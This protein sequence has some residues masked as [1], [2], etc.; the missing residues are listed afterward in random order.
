LR[1]FSYLSGLNEMNMITKT[2]AGITIGIT[3]LTAI[4]MPAL[5]P[6][7]RSASPIP[8]TPSVSAPAAQ[9][10]QPAHAAVRTMP[11]SQRIL[12]STRI[13][14]YV[15]F[16]RIPAVLTHVGNSNGNGIAPE[17]RAHF[18]DG[19][20]IR[21]SFPTTLQRVA[22]ED[23]ADGSR[24]IRTLTGWAEGRWHTCWWTV[25]GKYI[26]G[27]FDFPWPAPGKYGVR[28]KFAPGSF[29]L[30]YD[31]KGYKGERLLSDNVKTQTVT[32]TE[33]PANNSNAV[34][35]YY[36]ISGALSC[37]LRTPKYLF[38]SLDSMDAVLPDP[39]NP[40][41]AFG[42]YT[43]YTLDWRKK[44]DGKEVTK[45][46]TT[47]KLAQYPS[48]GRMARNDHHHVEAVVKVG[49]D[50][51]Q[52][53]SANGGATLLIHRWDAAQGIMVPYLA[54]YFRPFDKG[55]GENL[56]GKPDFSWG[57]GLL[58]RDANG[59]GITQASEYS[60][61]PA[62]RG[63]VTNPGGGIGLWN[64]YRLQVDTKGVVYLLPFAN[65]GT[66]GTDQRPIIR[67]NPFDTKIKTPAAL[68]WETLTV[69]DTIWQ[70]NAFESFRLD[71]KT[72]DLVA[73]VRRKT[74]SGFEWRLEL[75]PG[76][77]TATETA[78]KTKKPA[79]SVGNVATN[80]R[81][82]YNSMSPYNKAFDCSYEP[83]S[84]AMRG[85]WGAMD[86]A[87]DYVFVGEAQGGGVRVYRTSNGQA[88][89]R[90]YSSL[91]P[92]ATIDSPTVFHAALQGDEYRVFVQDFHAA[93]LLWR[94]KKSDLDKMTG[95]PKQ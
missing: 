67:W 79:F 83:A 3:A 50:L 38:Y 34:P 64:D 71:W 70:S 2:T 77:L 86:V 63:A 29:A 20:P 21:T 66:P 57:Q 95:I 40:N 26:G 53:S 81:R 68:A 73:M 44:G 92:N 59:D 51:Y 45:Y 23:H 15:D 54:T 12:N 11:Q 91:T 8:P 5:V 69:P 55:Q 46:R 41:R 88:V 24:L 19:A 78:R 42:T 39:T 85:A 30:G 61:F 49:A 17:D 62:S 18:G 32:I 48:D 13:D 75:Y 27:G 1:K 37:S 87:G 16:P 60:V 35:G 6:A 52:Y 47:I 28:Q 90:C 93:T 89:G 74:A 80:V 10:A 82:K 33:I 56:A 31:G 72:G 9:A 94:I 58:W 25:D 14:F 22:I 4:A 65:E 36:W 7:V 43:A 84:G 76:W